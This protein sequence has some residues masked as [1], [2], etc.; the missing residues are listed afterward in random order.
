MKVKMRERGRE[1]TRASRGHGE[2][3]VR[4]TSQRSVFGR[5]ID[6]VQ[7]RRGDGN[8]RQEGCRQSFGGYD[9]KIYN[10]ATAFFFTNF[11]EEWNYED[12]WRLFSKYGRI[13]SIYSPERR[14]RFGRR[15]G[16]VRFLEVKDKKELERQ[17]DQ[18]WIGHTKLRANIPRFKEEDRN[19]KKES[20]PKIGMQNHPDSRP[21][22]NQIQGESGRRWG[23]RMV[24]P[25][26]SYADVLRGS[27]NTKP[28]AEHRGNSRTKHSEKPNRR[29]WQKKNNDQEW[30]GFEF[31]VKEEDY[32]WLQG[33]YVGQAHSVEIVP[34]IQERFYMEGYFA[35]KLKA[36]G[37]KLVLLESEDK[38]ELK[39]LVENA[40][41][42]LGQWFKEIKPWSPCMVAN[43]RFVWIKCTGVPLH[44][45]GPT[46]FSTLSCIWGKFI[47]LDESTSKKKRFDIARFLICTPVMD[48]IS[49]KLKVKINGTVYNIRVAEEEFSNSLF[50]IKSDF[51]PDFP[52]DSE[53]ESKETW[54]NDSVEDE[55]SKGVDTEV[56]K[57]FSD[58][59][60]RVPREEEEDVALED[61][62]A[63]QNLK[64]Q[65]QGF[66]IEE[67]NKKDI[68]AAHHNSKIAAP[69]QNIGEQNMDAR[70]RLVGETLRPNNEETTESV[71]GPTQGKEMEK[72]PANTGD[73][74]QNA[75]NAFPVRCNQFT[76]QKASDD[77]EGPNRKPTISEGLEVEGN[78]S[79]WEGMAS[80]SERAVNWR[81]R[82]V[83]RKKSKNRTKKRAKS[84]IAVYKATSAILQKR[85]RGEKCKGTQQL[86][87]NLPTFL[88]NPKKVV[89]GESVG[90]SDII[91]RNKEIRK[92][93][94]KYR[95]EEIWEF[96]KRIG[97]LGQSEES[98]ICQQIK[99]MEKRDRAAKVG[100]KAISKGNGK[101]ESKLVTVDRRLCQALWSHDEF[102][103]VFKPSNGLSGGLICVWNLGVFKKD[104]VY[105]GENYIGVYGFW[106]K[107]A[108]PVHIINV[109]SPCNITS[110]RAL[111]QELKLLVLGTKGNWCLVGAF[112]A[113]KSRQERAEGKG[114][115][116][117][118]REFEDF[119]RDSNLVDLPLCGRRYTWY[120][121]NGASMN[122]IDRF[123]LSEDWLLNWNDCK[124]WGLG[125]SISDHCPIILKNISVDWGPRPFKWFDAWLDTLGLRD[126]IKKVW[127]STKVSG[128][129]GYCLKEKFKAVKRF[130][131]AWSMNFK[132]EVDRNITEYKAAI[133]SLDAKGEQNNLS[134]E[135]CV[136]RQRNFV[137]LWKCLKTKEGMLKQKSR[138]MW[139]KNGDANTCY[140]HRCVKS[141]IRKKE[142]CCLHMDGQLVDD[143][144]TL[145][146]KIVEHY[147]SYF[148]DEEWRRPTLDGIDFN[149]LSPDS[150][151][152]LVDNFTEEEVKKAAWDCGVTKAP[153]PDG[154]NFRFIREMWEVLKEDIM[155][156][157]QEFHENGKLVRGLNESFIV[158]IPKKE[159][160]LELEDF[161]PISLIGAMY[162]ILTKILANRLSRVMQEI[163][164]EQQTAFVKGRQLMDGV[165]VA[166]EVIDEVRRKRKS[167]F[168]FKID[169]EKAFDKVSWKFLDY[170][171]E[172]MGFDSK[173]RGWIQE[174]LSTSRVS[175]LVNGS[176]TD[177]FSVNQGLRQGDPLSSF[178]FLII[179]KGLNGIIASTIS[180]KLFAGVSV[181][182]NQLNISHL[183]FADDT[184]LFGYATEENIWAVKC[185]TRIFELVSGLKINYVKSQLMGVHV[186]EEWLSRAA[187][188][189]NCKLGVLP[190]KYLGVPIGDN[191]RR[192]KIWQPLV[193]NFKKKLSQW[194]GR[195]VSMGGRITL[196]NVVLSSLPVFLMSMFLIPKGVIKK[197]DSIRRAFLWGGNDEK[198]VINWVG[199]ENVCKSKEEGGLGVKNLRTFNLALMG[200]W[201]GRLAKGEGGLWH[202]V[203]KAKY[204]KEGVNWTRWMKENSELGSLW[205]RDVCRLNEV[206]G[207][208][209][210]WLEKGF[211][212]DVGE[213]KEM[214]FWKENWVGIEWRVDLGFEVEA[215]SPGRGSIQL[216]NMISRLNTKS[217]TK[218]RR[219]VWHWK[220][221]QN[222]IY[223]AS[224]GYQTLSRSFS[225]TR[226]VIFN[227]I[228]NPH[229]PTKVSAFSWLVTQD[230]IPSEVN[231]WRKGVLRDVSMIMCK[232]CEEGDESTR[233][234]FLHYHIANILWGRCCRWWGVE[235]V[236][237]ESCSEAFVQ[238]KGWFKDKRSREGWEVIW[239]AVIW[240][241]WLARNGKI[242]NNETVDTDQLFQLIQARSFIWLKE[243]KRGH[244]FSLS[245]WLQDPRS[246]MRNG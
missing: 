241:I 4:L 127:N 56:E 99:R 61:W 163:I 150:A 62:M 157:I 18:I 243:R 174:C 83:R 134:I 51:I 160:P 89:A 227:K 107:D 212:L 64:S 246:S 239:F 244:K 185:I 178:L 201:W 84:C 3:L 137:D 114:S 65:S 71:N 15:F 222:G 41:D 236:L 12:L 245:Y 118:M 196:I 140:F 139:I 79:F 14:D 66:E 148:K 46:F 164:G 125:R 21:V 93:W 86:K 16:F 206:G 225:S 69:L 169:F 8:I 152:M 106:G 235:G 10:Q 181:G 191:P 45:W 156:F 232:M 202:K 153:G 105:E 31:N 17:L 146:Q 197:L 37:G 80:E 138:K 151:A 213:G 50:S 184:I 147:T 13:Y 198:R 133:A 110:K 231:L 124:Q 63:I 73:D 104:R 179:A 217:L 2:S 24:V 100:T 223:S 130:L 189:L 171:L 96:A 175:I 135:E 87:E 129:K 205:W 170:M 115:T 142:I 190:F 68:L 55:A 42:W 207:S 204:G 54:E 117:E 116:T 47:T 103:W 200:K 59:E 208:N 53:I 97:V 23:S 26:R 94:K 81:E 161:R 123:L 226:G 78:N 229:I 192:S 233:H 145:R 177:Q 98:D 210:G 36:M 144:Q 5:Q 92:G 154:F 35:C 120:Q 194:K 240:T 57:L 33:C 60:I 237:A 43:E 186:D 25:H 52:S 165:V 128:W 38:D 119:I 158:L 32:S 30:T 183:Q 224:S 172:R 203:L 219:D 101:Q 9:W 91:N 111:W 166:N 67:T 85:N 48:S 122:R 75:K 149:R 1:R 70:H 215:C 218:G 131:K 22:N 6:Q 102:E 28:M 195:F 34:C 20:K 40:S 49:K 44:S 209:V 167:S 143:V 242:F 126:E 220:H 29:K 76:S 109:Y 173:W 238:H 7:R 88:P 221:D 82:Q 214:L 234:L 121:V 90:D 58:M 108:V 19:G 72:V 176:P 74:N 168:V 162:K 141:R 155:G 199:W 132:E 159:N 182:S 77:M 95:A 211:E 216:Q 228:W 180:Q 112:N 230:R 11:P 27:R 136:K 193:E 113:V 39:D 187:A 188:I